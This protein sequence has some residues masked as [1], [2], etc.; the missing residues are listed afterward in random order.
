MFTPYSPF[1]RKSLASRRT[2]FSLVEVVLAVGVISFA[3]VAILGLLPAGLHQFRQAM[4]T[5]VGAQIAQRVIQDCQLTD[6]D[7]LVDTANLTQNPNSIVYIRA[8][9]SALTKS[10]STNNPGACVRYFTEEGNEIIPATRTPQGNGDPSTAELANVVYYVNTRIATST[11]LPQMIPGG[12]PAPLS[13]GSFDLATV[14]VQVAF[15][16]SHQGIPVIGTPA[17]SPQMYL[18]DVSSRPGVTVRNY[19]AQIGRN[20]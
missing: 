12:Q 1:I 5:S 15:N 13:S 3:F 4:D 2:A 18:F 14:V 17:N 7:T 11:M 19:V 20:F 8:P 10:A 6:F 9:S 16:P